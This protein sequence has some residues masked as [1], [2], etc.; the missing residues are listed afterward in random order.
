M[1][2]SLPHQQDVQFQAAPDCRLLRASHA[3]AFGHVAVEL[4]QRGCA[5]PLQYSLVKEL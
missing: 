3:E 1:Q 2:V 4:E 5:R